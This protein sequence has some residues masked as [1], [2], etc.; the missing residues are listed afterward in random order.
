MFLPVMHS[1]TLMR[2]QHHLS[3]NN[4]FWVLAI[5]D[6]SKTRMNSLIFLFLTFVVESVEGGS[7]TDLTSC[8]SG[9]DAV[10]VLFR[11]SEWRQSSRSTHQLSNEL[12][13]SPCLVAAYLQSSCTDA[14]TFLKVYSYRLFDI[15]FQLWSSALYRLIKVILHLPLQT[16]RIFAYVTLS[17][18]PWSPHALLARMA[19]GSRETTYTFNLFFELT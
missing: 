9:I 8:S 1:G 10:G 5:K 7:V 3:H 15:I 14:C 18:T 16:P 4:H 12:G 13:Q 2:G 17:S 6:L 11:L 19:P